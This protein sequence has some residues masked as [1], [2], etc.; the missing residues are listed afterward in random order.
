MMP[1]RDRVLIGGIW[2]VIVWV[3]GFMWL[4]GY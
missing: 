1:V 2:I 4:A 3:V